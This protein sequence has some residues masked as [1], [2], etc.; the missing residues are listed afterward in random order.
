MVQLRECLEQMEALLGSD[1]GHAMSRR[2]LAVALREHV[3][4]ITK[5]RVRT[6]FSSALEAADV[7]LTGAITRFQF[8]SGEASL[9]FLR[10]RLRDYHTAVLDDTYQ[11]APLLSLVTLLGITG[12]EH[13]M[14]ASAQA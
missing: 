8:E 6:G 12:V 7:R 3:L 2:A 9:A 14:L 1:V 13:T 11:H 5:L 4:E 10:Q